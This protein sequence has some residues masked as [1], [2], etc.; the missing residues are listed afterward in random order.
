ML[1]YFC[2]YYCQDLLFVAAAAA[3]QRESIGWWWWWWGVCVNDIYKWGLE[4]LGF[5]N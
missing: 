1:H 2:W 5:G 3:A 4:L